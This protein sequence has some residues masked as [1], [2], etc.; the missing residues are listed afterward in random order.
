VLTAIRS[1]FRGKAAWGWAGAGTVLLLLVF[2]LL[3]GKKA[4]PLSVRMLPESDAVVY[5]NLSPVRSVT[6]LGAHPVP[7]DPDYQSF[8][9]ATGI[10]F[11]R[12]LDDAAFALHRT[13]D[14]L[15]PNGPVAYSEVFHGR[16]DPDRLTR[17]L[18]AQAT[19]AEHYAGR[20]I[21]TLPSQGRTVRVALLGGGRVAVSN[22]GSPEQIHSIL[23]RARSA[24]WLLFAAPTLVSE[25]YGD[26]PLLSLAWG[27]GELALPFT[28]HGAVRIFGLRMP[29]QLD[30]VFI[31]SLRWTG[32]VRLRLEEIAPGEAAA[33]ASAASLADLLRV[34]RLADG[35]LPGGHD[36][37]VRTLIDSAEVGHQ[38]DRAI[39]STSVPTRELERMFAPPPVVAAPG[40]HP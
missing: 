3:L 16:F 15:G 8:I 24:R 10:D 13:A 11:E 21:Y 38:G 25:H 27:L 40:S 31:A 32:Q 29:W 17:Y 9:D 4:P 28:D 36:G 22:T 35:A 30:A 18:A 23:D 12:D 26:V 14:P 19:G 37:A 1:R 7:H 33:A 20:T 34:A 39:L 2:W 6:G 5:F